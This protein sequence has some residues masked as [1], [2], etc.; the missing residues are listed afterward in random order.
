[1]SRV[2]SES[3]ARVHQPVPKMRTTGHAMSTEGWA[4]CLAQ[5]SLPSIIEMLQQQENPDERKINLNGQNLNDAQV[6]KLAL[7]VAHAECPSFA[8]NL[9]GAA[10]PTI[11]HVLAGAAAHKPLTQLNLRDFRLVRAEKS[12]CISHQHVGLIAKL[13]A[14]DSKLQVLILDG[15]KLLPSVMAD[16]QARRPKINDFPHLPHHLNLA[17]DQQKVFK[18]MLMA[19]GASKTMKT[20]SLAGCDL[21]NEDLGRIGN[22]LFAQKTRCTLITLEL[23]NN[24]GEILHSADSVFLAS[25]SVRGFLD[26]AAR[27]R[28]LE[29][30]D[31]GLSVRR[32]ETF[33][34]E[35]LALVVAVKT[36]C[37]VSPCPDSEADTPLEIRQQLEA[38]R[39]ARIASAM[40]TVLCAQQHLV[41]PELGDLMAGLIIGVQQAKAATTADVPRSQSAELV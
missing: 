8:L 37:H 21:F 5:E 22:A 33:D 27:A 11:G 26:L 18:R 15:Q 9:E 19:V 7:L 2:R 24:F 41:P 6:K 25:H 20:L 35:L 13:L 28:G 38:N 17:M 12:T 10:A 34:A 36:L 29:S 40:E 30:L 23:S 1:M 32:G 31:L 14:P 16:G 4:Q 3:P 39:H